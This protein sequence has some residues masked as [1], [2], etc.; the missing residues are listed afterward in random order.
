MGFDP[1]K[2][3]QNSQWQHQQQ[4]PPHYPTVDQSPAY[5][6]TFQ[7]QEGY[8]QPVPPSQAP[9]YAQAGSEG[10]VYPPQSTA[11]GSVQERLAQGRPLLGGEHFLRLEPLPFCGL[12]FGWFLF[13]LGFICVIPWYIGVLIYFCLAHDTR[14]K[15]GLLACTI[16]AILFLLAGGTSVILFSQNCV[17]AT[18]RSLKGLPALMM[19]QLGLSISSKHE[20]ASK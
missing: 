18:G 8:P 7:G 11:R 9:H 2:G 12:G 17:S 3:E 1:E 15:S 5:Y 20:M 6:G 16:A 13:I 4:Q 19:M 10:Y 14:E